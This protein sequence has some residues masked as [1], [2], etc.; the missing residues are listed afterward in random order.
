MND[1]KSD[2]EDYVIGIVSGLAIA[3]ILAI[4]IAA[5]LDE[6]V[7]QNA[8]PP[9]ENIEIYM[10]KSGSGLIMSAEDVSE[11]I[12]ESL[13]RISALEKAQKK[14]EQALAIH[15]KHIQAVEQGQDETNQFIEN[16]FE[17]FGIQDTTAH[18]PEITPGG[19]L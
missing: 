8:A 6:S 12:S 10:Q 2:N 14:T 15:K 18:S 9:K 19:K 17:G 1:M 13:T 5:V 3:A 7:A 4:V 16:L 11:G